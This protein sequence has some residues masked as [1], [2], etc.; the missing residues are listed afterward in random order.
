MEEEIP[1]IPNDVNDK[2]L[3]EKLIQV[4]SK[5]Q[6][7]V[8]SSDIEACHCVANSS[9]MSQ[10]N[11]CASSSCID[12]IFCN[13]LNLISN[14]DVGLSLFENIIIISFLAKSTFEFPF[15]RA[16]FLKCGIIAALMLKLYKK[17]FGS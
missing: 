10:K 7:N 4:L 3:E 13:N 1:E 11:T 16:M 8:S 9:N 5:I 6:V 12:L 2:S 14:Y 15:P 17:M